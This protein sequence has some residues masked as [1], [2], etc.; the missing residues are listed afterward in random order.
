V[1]AEP[2]RSYWNRVKMPDGR[3]Q[4]EWLREEAEQHTI[5]EIG[6][7]MGNR[8]MDA[9]REKMRRMGLTEKQPAIP[10]RE[11]PASRQTV[12]GLPADKFMGAI[13]DN[14]KTRKELSQEFD[15]SEGTIETIVAGLQ[16]MGFNIVRTETEGIIWPTRSTAAVPPPPTLWDAEY[17]HFLFGIVSDLHSGSK[18][19]QW[20]NLR[21]CVEE[22]YNEG[23]RHIVVPGDATAGRDVYKGQ[24]H[25]LQTVSGPEMVAMLV[26]YLPAMAGLTYEFMGG[27]HDASFIRQNGYNPVFDLAAQREDVTYVGFDMADVPVTPKVDARLWHPMGGVPYAYSYRMQK[28]A[29]E[30]AFAELAKV[31]ERKESPK[32]RLLLAGHLHIW[33]DF[34]AGPISC[35]QCMCFEGQSPYLKRKG[36]VPSIG[37]IV[38]EFELTDGDL[39]RAEVPRRK[40]FVE[41]DNDYMH[42][43]VPVR[44][45]VRPEPMFQWTGSAQDAPKRADG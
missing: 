3:S 32:L 29:E 36:K 28:M 17:G 43:P 4:E 26:E 11:L 31:I 25:D 33:V 40:K 5:G 23:V 6:A 9:I 27:N 12:E 34:D 22:M 7:L 2:N 41:I 19:A 18:F 42:Y 45:I 13:R 37:G 21:R 15:R 8:T 24:I 30:T 14:P 39:I 35:M 10:E 1:R 38:Y 44:E 20:T 16:A